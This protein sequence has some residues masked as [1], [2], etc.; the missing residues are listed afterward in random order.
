MGSVV[1]LRERLAARRGFAPGARGR[2]AARLRAFAAE[3]LDSD[4][5]LDLLG[6]E[7]LGPEVTERELTALIGAKVDLAL[8]FG[9]AALAEVAADALDG[10]EPFGQAS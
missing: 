5:L 9:T 3:L 6:E 8:I 10:K 7:G 1:D 4:E 2:L